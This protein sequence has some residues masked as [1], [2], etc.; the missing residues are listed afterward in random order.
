MKT[1][2]I[3]LYIALA[4]IALGPCHAA[5]NDWS[6][7]GAHA[8]QDRYSDLTQISPQNIRELQIAWRFDMSGQGDSETN[9]LVV[10]GTLYGYTPDLKVIALDATTGQLRWQFDAGLRGTELA[11]GRRFTGPSRGLALWRQGHEQRLFAGVMN[12][13]IALDPA[14][15]QPIKKFGVAGAVDLRDGLRGEPTQ[16]YVALTSPGILYKDLIIVGFRTSETAPAPPGDIRAYDVHTGSLRWTFR[17]IPHAGEFG[18]ETWPQ[19]AWKEAGAANDW[20]GMALD[21][22]RGIV[23]APT[24][25]AVP[26]FYGSARAGADLFANSLL[27][28]DANTGK[29]LWHFQGVHHD[30]WDRDFPSPPALLTVLRQGKPVEAVAQTTKQGVVFVFDRVKGTP[31]FPINEIP[32]LASNVPGETAST[33]QPWPSAPEPFARQRLT[34]D[35]LTRRTPESHAW[36][37]RQFATFRSEGQFVPLSVDKQTVVFPGFDGGAEW[38]GAAVD[39]RAG[40]LFVNAN[41]IA[42]TGGL[43]KTVPGG[44]L[45]ASLFQAQCAS[46]HGPD[47]KGSPPAF[48]DLTDVGTRLSAAQIAD[49][50]RNGRGRM[51]PFANIQSFTL[52]TLIEYLRTGRES[53]GSD[54]HPVDAGVATANAGSRR[55]MTVSLLSSGKAQPYAFTGYNKFLDPDGYPAVAPPWGTLNAIDLNSGQYLWKVPLGEYPELAAAGM[56]DTG[57][58]NYGGPILTASGLLFIGATVFDHELR[59]FDARTGKLLWHVELPFAGCA[60]PATYMANGRQFVVIATN[61]A[62]NP[63]A[64]QGAAYVAYSIAPSPATPADRVH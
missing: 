54:S 12:Y 41:D 13:L 27:A 58:E 26:D 50:I 63:K 37:E 5:D 30:L 38:G 55:E 9:P 20:A 36:A 14:T 24:G 47:R 19:A 7:Y 2:R 32:V 60:T 39:P 10:E 56:R 62:R 48:P 4:V 33:T 8:S 35:L 25:S 15:G 59:A 53:V 61:N 17:T 46:C 49:V 23:Y 42:W 34:R 43:V 16:H 29:R 21:A 52:M 18:H 22:R 28:L 51:P 64:V 45:A 57:S 11:P 6:S 44:G 1:L 3:R 31:L 40:I